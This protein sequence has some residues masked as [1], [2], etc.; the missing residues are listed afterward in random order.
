VETHKIIVVQCGAGRVQ[1]VRTVIRP[2]MLQMRKEHFYMHG[3]VMHYRN[4]Y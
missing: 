2:L 4:S 1:P 3:G